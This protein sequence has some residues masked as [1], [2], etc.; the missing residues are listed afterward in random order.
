MGLNLA[1][2]KDDS[3]LVK[4][5]I[6]RRI[7]VGKKEYVVVEATVVDKL[8]NVR[9]LPQV[10]LPKDAALIVAY[11]GL[12]P[13]WKVLDV[14]TGSAFLAIFLAN[15]VRPGK[16]LSYEKRKDFAEHAKEE[17]K[18]LGIDN[19][20]IVNK[21]IFQSRVRGKFDLITLD[22]KGAENAI[23][24]LH[25]NLK[26]GRF[27]AIY[28]PHLEQVKAVRKVLEELKYVE[29]KTVENIVRE[30]KVTEN[31]T[32]PHPSGILHTGF[33]TIARKYED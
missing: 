18:R 27:F 19:L 24:H 23:R 30:W 15:L 29:I 13:G 9:R 20:R 4:T 11:T 7:R 10:V 6:G 28:S 32:H 12:A 8:K 31:Y 14:G 25:R 2:G 26:L 33:I 21:D 1:L 5:K 16:V 22:L 17:V 3:F